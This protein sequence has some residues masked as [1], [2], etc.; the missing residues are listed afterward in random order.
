MAQSTSVA[1]AVRR[2]HEE[3]A[4]VAAAL[5]ERHTPGGTAAIAAPGDT[6]SSEYW[7]PSGRVAYYEVNGQVS[8]NLGEPLPTTDP[9][10]VVYAHTRYTLT[11]HDYWNTG[12]RA[13]FVDTI[14]I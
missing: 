4:K 3:A 8:V 2:L 6:S 11:E 12:W 13:T 9:D 14:G 1:D 10:R 5:R 7:D